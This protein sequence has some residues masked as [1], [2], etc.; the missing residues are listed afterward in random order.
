M[1]DR[2]PHRGRRGDRSATRQFTTREYQSTATLFVATQNGTTV[3]E[4]Y[5]NNLFSTDRANSYAT[6]ATSEQVAAR[7]V[8]QLKGSITPEELRAKI[9]A[10]AAPKTVLFNVS[11]VDADPALAQTYANAVTDQLVGLVSEL[12]TSRRGGT[13]A[14]GGS[15]S[16]RRT[17]RPNP[18]G[19]DCR[20][21]SVSAPRAA[22]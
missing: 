17:I 15:W 22:S 18:S 5:Q 20:S 16:T 21:E 13:P 9:S 4:A 3:T 8:D 7:A 11:V 1:G 12:E 2:H 14:A 10:V 19:W 6:L